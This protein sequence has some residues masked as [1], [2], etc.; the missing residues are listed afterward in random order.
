MKLEKTSNYCIGSN[1]KIK[2]FENQSKIKDV[3]PF[4]FPF[5]SFLYSLSNIS[6][7]WNT[8]F[9]NCFNSSIKEL[10]II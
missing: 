4:I 9:I 10:R 7:Y 8:L 2:T 1:I 5:L 6:S 3:E